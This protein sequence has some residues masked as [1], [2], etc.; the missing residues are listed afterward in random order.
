MSFLEE[1]KNLKNESL[2]EKYENM[3]NQIRKRM[4]SQP[5][6]K[7][8]ISFEDQNPEC[9]GKYNEIHTFIIDNLVKEGFIVSR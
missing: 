8:F 9:S 2:N 3:K 1:M 5:I 6:N 4:K 7:M